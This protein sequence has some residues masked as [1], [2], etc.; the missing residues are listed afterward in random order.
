M[1]FAIEGIDGSGKATQAQILEDR[2]RRTGK[3]IL[4]V[5]FPA[6]THD[7]YGEAVTRYL[8]GGFGDIFNIPPE[9]TAL[10]FAGN[11]LACKGAIDD[12]IAGGAIVVADRYVNSNLAHQG[13]KLPS[14]D[15]SSFYDWIL[16]I[17]FGVH[18]LPRPTVN[19]LIDT[20]VVMAAKR[21]A[22]RGKR[23][24]TEQQADFHEKDSS[25][26]E[27]CAAVYRDLLPGGKNSAGD[28]PWVVVDSAD[29]AGVERGVQEVADS[30]WAAVQPFLSTP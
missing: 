20:P 26:L 5:S 10:L 18:Q 1:L 27:S 14:G 29:R 2:L 15:R 8:N 16:R 30:I 3:E 12:A 22:M 23:E 17:E 19:I 11:R 25:Y 24:Y 13:A 28:D 4:S 6:F 21:I 7:A 9:L